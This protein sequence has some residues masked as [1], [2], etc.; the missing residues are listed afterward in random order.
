MHGPLFG[1]FMGT[2][3]LTLL[4][5]GVVANVLLKRSKGEGSGWIVIATGWGLGVLAGI[6]TAIACGSPGA[7]IN[8]A[9]TLA[10]AITSHNW[11][12]VL[13]FLDSTNFGRLCRRRACMACLPAA[14][15]GNSRPGCEAGNLLYRACHSVSS[16]KRPD[17]NHRHHH[18]GRCGIRIHR[19]GGCSERTSAW[20]CSIS[21]GA[22][23]L[24]ARVVAWRSHR[25]C[26][27]PRARF[28]PAHGA[29]SF[30]DC[31]EGQIGLGLCSYPDHCTAD[32]R[33]NRRGQRHDIPLLTESSTGKALF[34]SR[35]VHYAS[36][37]QPVFLQASV[38]GHFG[39]G[40]RENPMRSRVAA[41]NEIEKGSFDLCVIGGGAT[42]AGC[43]LDAQLR[44][45]RAVLV[46]AGDFAG[47]TSG[48]S[49]KLIHGGVRYLKQAISECDLGQYRVIRRALRERKIM[50]DN[51]PFLAHPIELMVPCFSR[52]EIYYFR[53]GMKLYDWISGR[54]LL[55]QSRYLSR[56]ESLRRMPML[57]PDRLVGTIAY[58]DGQFDDAR[59]NL[60][61]LQSFA[62]S[63]GE[64]L[65]YA[66][67][68]GFK[69]DGR[70]Q[71]VQ[72]RVH[73]GLSGHYFD[74]QAR[75]FLNA[76][77]P[78]ADGIR[79]LAK[80]GVRKRLRL[81]KG[82]HILL[83]M[84]KAAGNDAL[85]V[86][87]TDDGRVIFAIPWLGRLL[88]GTTD[89]EATLQDEMVVKEEEAEYLLKHV[90]RYLA[91]PFSKDQI[92]S[93]FAGMRPLVASGNS[94]GTK[95]LIRDHEV[96]VES[97][98]GLI[99][100]LG[101]KWTTYRAMAEDAINTVME[102]LSMPAVPCIT[103]NHRLSG[104]EGW[105][106]NFWQELVREYGVSQE[107]ARHLSQKF[108]AT[109]REVLDLTKDDPG[110][111][112]PI[113]AGLPFVLAEVVYGVREEMAI[114]IEDILARRTGL[115]L[116]SW[117]KARTAA[118]AVGAVMA[119]ELGW[120][121]S[122]QKDA[123]EEYIKKIGRLMRL[124]GLLPGKVTTVD[125]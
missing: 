69:K 65:N 50:L 14:L 25:I 93:G 36:L 5:D 115:Q 67:V 64:A 4:G 122:Q 23:G 42:G 28:R 37:E 120:S 82:S 2:M 110:L 22:F 12:N 124:I 31:W 55:S 73:D 35:F 79:E 99:S 46:E 53:I 24:G 57:K 75:A 119:G 90:N 97:S 91:R 98:S 52:G 49:T 59:Y 45:L 104:F 78:F 113:V 86:P 19:V 18:S 40:T 74:I 92:V 7:H 33:C 108:G 66:R 100:V 89:E 70:G 10:V 94:R 48:S 109:A 106:P 77:G 1:E 34:L 71:I 61:L 8:P 17:G 112:K 9:V 56:E 80:S 87:K 123:V 85:L 118:P 58:V 3:V 125:A 121:P 88:V 51:A 20:L 32:R 29:L 30:A 96:E 47:A 39:R 16:G 83:P 95:D 111:K 13:P 11:A 103:S 72:A 15:E 102:R 27:E 41:L 81:S 101:G 84:D 76:T 62:K 68:V 63:G 6:F 26:H 105:G 114:S 107:T 117:E 116:F 54:N 21:L 60:A 44:G 38:L 43:A